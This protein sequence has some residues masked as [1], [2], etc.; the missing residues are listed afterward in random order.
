MTI[1]VAFMAG[2]VS[3]ASPCFLPIVPVFIAQLIGGTPGRVSRWSAVWNAVAFIVGFSMVFIGLWV[4]IG[5]FGHVIGQYSEILR[6]SGG[7]VLIVLGLHMAQLIRIPVLDRQ[8][9]GDMRSATRVRPGVGRSGLMGLIF[10]AGWTPCIGPI[11]GGILALASQTDT[12]V[13]G[14]VLMLA[15][16]VGLGLPIVLV[17][18]GAVDVRERFGWFRRHHD[19]ISLVSGALLVVVGF[20][21]IVNMFERLVSWF[22]VVA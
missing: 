21:M 8:F 11:L 18:V 7:S 12:V 22:P 9:S 15:Y 4:S 5:L 14:I 17:A 16:C 10:G 13:R 3:F 1:A 19:A 6:V 20:L 2:I